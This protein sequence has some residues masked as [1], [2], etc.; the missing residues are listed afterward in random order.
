MHEVKI[1]GDGR[2]EVSEVW[3]RKRRGN[4]GR[5]GGGESGEKAKYWAKKR[6]INGSVRT[7]VCDIFYSSLS[8]LFLRKL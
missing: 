5:A 1:K 4:K 7:Y 2:E 3:R 8:L 6:K